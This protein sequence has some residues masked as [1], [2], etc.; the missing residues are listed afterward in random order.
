MK[1]MY[2]LIADLLRQTGLEDFFVNIISYILSI[3]IV[4]IIC[5]IIR[6]VVK[7]L[8]V[9]F[10][11][12]I[13][14]R[15]ENSWIKIFLQNKFFAR[16]S[17]LAVPLVMA[18]FLS[19]TYAYHQF[20][21][22]AVEVILIIITLSVLS[23]CIKSI[24]EIYSLYEVSK[25]IPI[26]GFLQITEIAAFVIGGIIIISAVAGTN[27]AMLLGSI[28]AMTA[29]TTIVFKDVI[30]GFVAG[31]QLMSN[32]MIKIGDVIECQNQ[33]VLGKV[34]DIYLTTIKI[35]SLDN[36]IILIPAY[37]LVSEPFT[38]RRGI[39]SAGSRRIKRAINIDATGVRV[40]DGVMLEKFKN[41]ELI[42]NHIINKLEDIEESNKR[43]DCDMSENTNGRRL[44]NIGV[45]RAYLTEYLKNH[46][47]IRQ[48]LTLMIR[49]LE[50]QGNGLPLEVYAFADTTEWLAFEN[51]Q[52]DIFD[53]IYAVISEFGLSLY[54]TPS[55]NDIRQISDKFIQK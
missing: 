9:K 22:V 1:F 20:W 39:L 21:H 10:F 38:N 25:T 11:S 37:S 35:E 32:D 34:I 6:C 15:K 27:P 18:A 55:S 29:I 51:I 12:L 33:T 4:I 13:T 14:K 19:D 54:Q 40:C 28:G 30:L 48:D 3:V 23:A 16:A 53:H 5:I 44:T 26:R 46:S 7:I 24:G 8:A 52:S 2:S 49:Q 45:F 31:I 41:I 43:L 17:N 50:P 36:T 47:M 42:K